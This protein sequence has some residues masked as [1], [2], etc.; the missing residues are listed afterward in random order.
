MKLSE[1]KDWETSILK[2][3]DIKQLLSEQ[4]PNEGTE[5]FPNGSTAKDEFTREK[6]LSKVKKIKNSFERLLIVG[7]EVVEETLST[8]YTRNVSKYG[9]ARLHKST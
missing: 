4:Y 8:L 9:Q 5:E 3:D 2:C 1:G 6:I 7:R